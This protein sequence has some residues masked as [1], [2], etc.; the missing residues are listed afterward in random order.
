[1]LVLA[2][3]GLGLGAAP[4]GARR[5]ASNPQLSLATPHPAADSE[6]TFVVNGAT[7][8]LGLLFV[9]DTSSRCPSAGFREVGWFKEVPAGIGDREA[10]PWQLRR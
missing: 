1:M 2:A 9:F 7:A 6:Y 8:D 5:S 10:C 4:A 3:A